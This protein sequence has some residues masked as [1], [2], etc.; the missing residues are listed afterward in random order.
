MRTHKLLSLENS[1]GKNKP[2]YNDKCKLELEKDK[3]DVRELGI[4][5][6]LTRPE[7]LLSLISIP[8]QLRELFRKYLIDRLFVKDCIS[9]ISARNDEIHLRK[10][11]QFICN[12]YPEINDLTNL[13]RN[14]IV[15]YLDFLKTT[16]MGGHR[17][18]LYKG[19]PITNNSLYRTIG[20]LENFL[21][22]IQR[23]EWLEAPIKPIRNLMYQEDRPKVEKKKIE[24]YEIISDYVWAQVLEN[25]K[26]MIPQYI[27]I[28]LLLESTGLQF[29]ELLSL[30]L[31][32]LYEKNDI[33]MIKLVK[34]KGEHHQI[35][36]TKDI[37]AV[38]KLQQLEISKRFP[39]N[40]N[41]LNLLFLKLSGKVQGKPFL[42]PTF[43][44]YM[45]KFSTDFNIRDEQGK[46]VLFNCSAFRNRFGVKK[47]SAGK[48]ILEVQRL[49]TNVT[50]YMAYLCAKMQ[51]RDLDRKWE[52]VKEINGIR[53]NPISGENEIIYLEDL[54]EENGLN[55]EWL[56]RNHELLK[57]N[58]G[59]CIRPL[60]SHCQFINQL[61]EVPCFHHKCQ[62]FYVDYTFINFYQDQI[63]TMENEIEE[64]K[65]LSR[66][67]SIEILKPKLDKY[68]EILLSL[69]K[70]V[71]HFEE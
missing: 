31:D 15:E 56:R 5:F 39:S 62:S 48:N 8:L 1:Y 65:K 70:H 35:T 16:S 14:D 13:E 37:A 9:W 17:Y 34:R 28:V 54:A 32:C 49:F 3:W 25:L 19:K 55:Q 61:I 36:I 29:F 57:M 59:Y 50:P 26:N 43:Y 12:K 21:Y 30:K 52:D 64:H 18:S 66:F 33:Y 2:F 51:D 69:E 40:K 47:L 58:H 60:N 6:S 11:F 42:G 45:N 53:L 67:R 71:E 27:P 41:H 63:L 7:Y 4:P 68:R 23:H 44:R 22:Y 10:F 46:I 20:F 24:D 38:V